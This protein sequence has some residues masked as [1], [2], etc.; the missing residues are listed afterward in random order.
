M[1][2]AVQIG[3]LAATIVLIWVGLLAA[4]AANRQAKAAEMQIRET[5]RPVLTFDPARTDLPWGAEGQRIL[6]KNV[7]QGLAVNLIVVSLQK[8]ALENVEVGEAWRP[9]L[10]IAPG[11]SV[12]FPFAG[13]KFEVEYR[14]LIGEHFKTIAL[15]F[16]P[17]NVAIFYEQLSP[18]PAWKADRK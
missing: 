7:G 5:S 17:T 3:M 16:E 11:I 4:K 2:L 8:T 18:N 10:V 14:S 15:L 6:I 12:W 13:N 1:E 9:G